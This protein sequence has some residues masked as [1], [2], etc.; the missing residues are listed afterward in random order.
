MDKLP[1]VGLNA[2]EKVAVSVVGIV[3]TPVAVKVLVKVAKGVP[4]KVTLFQVIPLVA[5]VES[6]KIFNVEP[7][8]SIVPAVYVIPPFNPI[9]ILPGIVMVPAVLKVTGVLVVAVALDTLQVPVP[10]KTNRVVPTKL[11][12]FCVTLPPTFKVLPFMVVLAEVTVKF[13][14]TVQ[15]SARVQVP[16]SSIRF[17]VRVLPP[18]VIVALVVKARVPVPAI[19]IPATNVT[20]VLTV[21][22]W[23]AVNVRVLV[24]PVQTNVEQIHVVVSIEQAGLLPSKLQVSVTTGGA[25][26]CVAPPEV[27]AQLFKSFQWE[28]VC[29]TKNKLAIFIY[30]YFTFATNATLEI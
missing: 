22:F 12:V 2:P 30:P 6:F 4:L 24:Y 28:S 29:P 19:V 15:V 1:N 25:A 26:G 13:P 3:Q 27:V 7:V 18:E 10:L 17:P 8:V 21:N 9:F 20:V 16:P 5:Y 11:K 23:L 14:E